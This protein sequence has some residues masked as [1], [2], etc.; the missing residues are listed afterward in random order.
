[1]SLVVPK[2][3]AKDINPHSGMLTHGSPYAHKTLKGL[4]RTNV[5]EFYVSQQLYSMI[6]NSQ[7]VADTIG[8]YIHRDDWDDQ[9]GGKAV[10]SRSINAEMYQNQVEPEHERLASL[11]S[12]HKRFIHELVPELMEEYEI[13]YDD[14]WANYNTIQ[15]LDILN[16]KFLKETGK[17]II[18]NPDMIDPDLEFINPETGA[19]DDEEYAFGPDSYADGV[20]RPEKLF[21]NSRR[22]RDNPYWSELKIEYSNAPEARGPGNKYKYMADK[23][24]ERNI[25]DDETGISARYAGVGS[26]HSKRIEPMSA[27]KNARKREYSRG[28]QFPHWQVTVQHRPYEWDNSEALREG[29]RSGRRVNPGRLQYDMSTLTNRSSV[30][31]RSVPFRKD[32]Y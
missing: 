18:Q 14:D 26:S 2:I 28:G 27:R 5:N 19:F 22:N 13:P 21:T 31:K 23:Y 30:E 15:Q 6:S 16:R 17:S 12:H 24:D 11:F 1:M 10:A 29:G 20:W 32:Y 4:F 3:L 25:Y 9:R 7:F 8:G